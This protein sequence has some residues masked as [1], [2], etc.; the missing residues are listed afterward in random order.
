ML[1][2]LFAAFGFLLLIYV[3]ARWALGDTGITSL[4]TAGT[5]F[6][7]VQLVSLGVTVEYICHVH[8]RAPGRPA[9]AVAERSGFDPEDYQT[10]SNSI[11]RT[12]LS[13]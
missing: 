9:Y 12:P 7:C 3:M 4:R 5:L 11:A 6:A 2:F 10:T 1:G 13:Y 8:T